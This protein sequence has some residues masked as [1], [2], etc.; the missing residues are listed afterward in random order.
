MTG[1]ALPKSI[2]KDY[3]IK[4]FEVYSKPNIEI[5][6]ATTYARQL[7]KYLVPY[8]GDIDIEDITT[9]DIQRFF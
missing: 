1:S 5:V 8:F 9:D 7:K 2:F 3:A 6:I 4:W